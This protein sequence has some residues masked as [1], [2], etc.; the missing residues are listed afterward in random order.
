M[1]LFT[2]YGVH[3]AL[4]SGSQNC[5]S[6]SSWEVLF[7]KRI[8][9]ALFAVAV[10]DGVSVAQNAAS[11]T[12]GSTSQA[13][14][15][16]TGPSAA[17][18]GANA[19]ATASQASK[20]SD[21]NAQ[22]AGASQLQAGSTVQAEL[23]KPVDA[24]KSK[25]GDEVLAKTT[26]DVKSEGHVVVPKGSKLVGHVTEVKA[27][28]KE[29]ATSE[30][31][32]AFDHAILKNGTEMP[33]ALGIQA[34][35]RSQASAAAMTDDTM[36]TGSAGAMGSSGARASGGG[37]MLGGVRSTAGTA[38]DTAGT[39]AGA[40]VN[41]VGAAGGAASGSLSTSSQGVVG[42]PGLSLSTQT[43][44]SANASVISSQGSNVHLDSGTEM[45]LR[46]NQ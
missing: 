33:L 35:G 25:V 27:S 11:Q 32:I 34:I 5:G 23:V 14:S 12:S 40:T 9:V 38:V 7:M 30:L 10:L 36:A 4:L 44:T 42:L 8:L 41:T 13:A 6:K 15:V 2:A 19:S 26:H 45:I 20:V 16:A 46:V 29:Q 28:S 37:G 18:T 31:G 1:H 17:Q 22:V 24:R 3:P 21:R 43:S 39:T